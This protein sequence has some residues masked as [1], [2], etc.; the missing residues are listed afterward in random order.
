MFHIYNIDNVI[1]STKTSKC[2]ATKSLL[3]N[4]HVNNILFSRL[5]LRCFKNGTVYC[6]AFSYSKYNYAY[7]A[8]ISFIEKKLFSQENALACIFE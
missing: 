5:I 2:M 4:L 8:H 3:A 1:P 7:I 6:K